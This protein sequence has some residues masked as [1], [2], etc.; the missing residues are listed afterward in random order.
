[1]ANEGLIFG[2]PRLRLGSLVVLTLV[3]GTLSARAWSLPAEG[4][5]HKS[6]PA[7]TARHAPSKADKTE[8][9]NEAFVRVSPSADV[10]HGMSERPLIQRPVVMLEQLPAGGS[11]QLDCRPS[12]PVSHLELAP[13]ANRRPAERHRLICR[14]A[15]APPIDA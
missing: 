14:F 12:L 11:S 7:K 9:E 1:M 8:E 13:P 2:F 3:A 15:H 4:D 10:W 5:A 6:K